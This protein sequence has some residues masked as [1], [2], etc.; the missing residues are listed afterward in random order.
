[1]TMNIFEAGS[2]YILREC[3]KVSPFFRKSFKVI[4]GFFGKANFIKALENEFL[5]V[6]GGHLKSFE[7]SFKRHKISYKLFKND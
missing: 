2:F 4:S 3:G 1:M 6:F 5:L 7:R